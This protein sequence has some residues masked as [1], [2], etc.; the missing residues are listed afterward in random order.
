MGKLFTR[1]F[2][3]IFSKKGNEQNKEVLIQYKQKNDDLK[4]LN[5]GLKGKI[6]EP[7]TLIY[8]NQEELTV[9]RQNA[10]MIKTN[11]NSEREDDCK[12]WERIDL[13]TRQVSEIDN[14]FSDYVELIEAMGVCDSLKPL[15]KDKI[16]IANVNKLS[17]KEKIAF[18]QFVGMDFYMARQ[19]RYYMEKFKKTNPFFIT[20]EEQL[21]I[22]KVNNFYHNRSNKP[23]DY[24]VLVLLGT[25]TGKKSEYRR[26]YMRD[27]DNAGKNDFLC[28][29]GIYVP[30]LRTE[31]DNGY[32]KK[33]IVKGD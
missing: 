25:E 23:C 13:L 2:L 18:I 6:N 4:K 5:D 30:A 16:G 26:K 21:M 14:Y 9:C 11:D 22:E 33:A 29:E 8:Q 15:I 12:Y 28:I 27:M 31:E 1:I 24:D 20:R 19:I 3:K 7:T 17:I 10:I 32:E